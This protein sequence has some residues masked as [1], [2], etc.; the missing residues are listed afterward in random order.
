MSEATQDEPGERAVT[1]GVQPAAVFPH[2]PRSR[3]RYRGPAAVAATMVL[4]AGAVWYL[5]IRDSEPKNDV[6]RLQGEWQIHR[7]GK[8]TP[9]AV[10]IAG[11][12]WEYVPGKAWRLTL[13]ESAAPRRIDLELQDMTGLLGPRPKLHGVYA[14]DG[15]RAIRIRLAPASEPR[16]G[17]LN[18]D[19]DVLELRRVKLDD[20][21]RSG[22]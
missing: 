12:T 16:P 22:M 20:A 15:N 11:N 10:R 21:P 2:P 7:D 17:S 6:E 19:D 9:N 14:F 8:P 5:A 3:R 1:T 4:A 13:D 18:D